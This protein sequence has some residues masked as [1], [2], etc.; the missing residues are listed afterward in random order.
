MKFSV[1]IPAY[2]TSFL[3]ECLES[4]LGQTYEDFEVVVVNDASPEDITSVVRGFEDSRIRYYVN[5]VNCGAINVVDNWNLCL[6]YAKGDYV[7]CMGDDDKLLP[8]CLDEYIKL[9]G[10]YPGLGVYHAWAQ[11]ID[12]NSRI[13][14]MQEPRPQF[15]GVYSMIWERWRGRQQYIGDFLFERKLL[16]K[17][18]GFYKTPLAWGADDITVCIAASQHGI[19]NMQV[20]GFQ[21]R[22]SS[23]TITS[24]GDVTARFEAI[25]IEE[26]WYNDFF[27]LERDDCDEV[28]KIFMR[29]CK[30][31]LNRAMAKKRVVTIY[32]ELVRGGMRKLYNI[33]KRRKSYHLNMQMIGYAL[34]ERLK[35]SRVEKLQK[36]TSPKCI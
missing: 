13:I 17:N 35:V 6:S 11:V 25:N 10:K 7:L 32:E 8:A 23:Q 4:V 28:E 26:G 33:V 9:I 14:S 16:M 1:I 3:R 24:L 22:V 2:K 31:Y 29:M 18:G 34:V 36:H 27:S 20:P 30:G 12:E 21:Y 19:A 15:E 5:E